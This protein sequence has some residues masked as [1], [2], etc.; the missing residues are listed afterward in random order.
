M[1][2]F[3]LHASPEQCG[4]VFAKAKPKL[5]A[6]IHV[7]LKGRTRFRGA[8]P[9]ARGAGDDRQKREGCIKGHSSP[10]PI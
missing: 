9:G 8:I 1:A 10:V 5:A 6:S 3:N 7:V 4:E 2:I